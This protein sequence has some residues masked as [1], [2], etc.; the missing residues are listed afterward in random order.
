MGETFPLGLQGGYHI[1]EKSVFID[2]Q[3][4]REKETKESV[5]YQGRAREREKN[6]LGKGGRER[7][8]LKKRLSVKFIQRANQENV[9]SAAHTSKISCLV[10]AKGSQGMLPEHNQSTQGNEQ[11]HT[12][13]PHS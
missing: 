13:F 10:C 9:V 12:Q 2:L 6:K 11:A 5:K 7:N 8:S 4:R 3:L 1:E